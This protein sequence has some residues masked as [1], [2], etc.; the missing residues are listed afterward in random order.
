MSKSEY[1]E[2]IKEMINKG[3]F[4]MFINL[5]NTHSKLN[6]IVYSQFERQSYLTSSEVSNFE[7]KNSYSI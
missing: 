3:S 1:K 4:Q 5:K 7:E 2:K 6:D